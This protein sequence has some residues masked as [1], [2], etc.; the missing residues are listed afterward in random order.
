MELLENIKE[1][2][3]VFEPNILHPKVFSNE[4]ELDGTPFVVPEAQGGFGFIIPFSKKAG[5][6]EIIG[7]NAGLGKA[8]TALANFKVNPAVT[9]AAFK[10]VLLHEFRQNVCNLNVDIFRVRHWSIEVE[11]L[12]VNGAE[13]CAWAREHAVEKQ[14]DEFKGCGVGSP[15][16]READEFAANGDTGAIRIIFS[17]RSSHTTMVWQV[18]FC[19]W[20]GML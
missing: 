2:V 4:T 8:I 13:T 20:T 9:L 3:Q 15:V 5:S 14:L 1:M 19:L 7:K 12:E 17:S 16:T 6:E 18:S 11:V 10:F